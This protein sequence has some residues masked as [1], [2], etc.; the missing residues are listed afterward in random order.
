VSEG[1]YQAL[2]SH[3]EA[4][5]AAVYRGVQVPYS[6]P[7]NIIIGSLTAADVVVAFAPYL[8]SMAHHLLETT[9]SLLQVS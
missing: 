8:V 5:T 4:Q 6:L 1:V 3:N 9:R 7:W 2:H